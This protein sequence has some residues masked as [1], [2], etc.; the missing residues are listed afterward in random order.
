MLLD[1]QIAVFCDLFVEQHGL[2]WVLVNQV[3]GLVV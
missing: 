3:A 1:K 2:I